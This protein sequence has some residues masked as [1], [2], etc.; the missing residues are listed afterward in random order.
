LIFAIY[1]ETFQGVV[2]STAINQILTPELHQALIEKNVLELRTAYENVSDEILK[3]NL[4]TKH[5]SVKKNPMHLFVLTPFFR[6]RPNKKT[7]TVDSKNSFKKVQKT[8]DKRIVIYD[9]NNNN[10]IVW[11]VP[12]GYR[13]TFCANLRN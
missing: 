13:G 3:E 2:A 6:L 9:S 8:F 11:T 12:F 10:P 5:E 1:F 4:Q 7:L